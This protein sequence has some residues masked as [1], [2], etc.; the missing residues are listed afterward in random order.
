M[1]TRAHTRSNPLDGHVRARQPDKS[2]VEEIPGLAQRFDPRTKTPAGERGFNRKVLPLARE[3]V[4]PPEHYSAGFYLANVF[5][6]RDVV[7]IYEGG[8]RA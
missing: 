6:H 1:P 5:R 4:Q 2:Q 8:N 7:R 3:I